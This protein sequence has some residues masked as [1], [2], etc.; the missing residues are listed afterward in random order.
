MDP[1]TAD[2]TGLLAAHEGGDQEALAELFRRVYREL[3]ALAGRQRRRLKAGGTLDSVA[4]VSECYLKLA[5]SDKA[6]ATDRGH[7]FAVAACAM[8]HLIVDY[9]RARKRAK[10]SGVKVELDPEQAAEER[11]TETVLAVQQALGRLAEID[12]RL[13]AVV[14]CRFFA[15]YSVEETAEALGLSERTVRRSWQAVRAHLGPV[16][17]G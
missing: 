2:I 1:S 6:P 12:P 9:A 7:F 3:H 15:G 17:G 11:E 4:L 10:R 16:L 14:E 13:V 5:R 8:R